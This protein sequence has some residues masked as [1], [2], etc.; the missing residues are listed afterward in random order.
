MKIRVSLFVYLMALVMTFFGK[1]GDFLSYFAAVVLHELA[2]A[3]YAKRRGYALTEF[4]LMPYGAALIGEFED[5][6][7]GDEIRIAAAGPLCNIA[8]ILLSVALW[9]LVPASYCF[10]EQ[11][12]YANL[13]LAAVNL[14]P[15]YPLD[16]GRI[17]LALLS[18][19]RPR[20]EAYKKLRIVGYVVGAAFAAAFVASCFFAANPTFLSMSAFIILSTVV[21]DHRCRY[22]RLYR[23]TNLDRKA[24]KGLKVQEVLISDSAPA[25]SLFAHLRS[26]FFTQFK[27]VGTDFE[28]VGVLSEN[29][30]ND[31]CGA[32]FSGTVG[33]LIGSKKRKINRK[34]NFEGKNR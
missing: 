5:V 1:I 13:S 3:E 24:K 23:L 21:P 27:V 29:E 7:R 11:F 8:L 2:H 9:W 31:F 33:E 16:G 6:S 30:L 12:V 17:A 32:D 18:G 4:R 34:M 26:D 15:V 14:L 19:K 22:E 28:A 25:A 20:N 10:T